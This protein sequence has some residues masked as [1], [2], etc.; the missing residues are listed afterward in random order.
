MPIAY[1]IIFAGILG[2]FF[3]EIPGVAN[4]GWSFLGS[5]WFNACILG[6][7]IFPLIIKKRIGE[8]S[9][10]GALLF[11]GVIVFNILLIVVKI[12]PSVET[13][14]QS[15]D[16]KRFY[17]F[18]FNIAFLSSLST[19]FVAYGFQSGFFPIYNALKKKSYRNGIKFATYSMG[20][21]FMIYVLIMFTGLYNFGT[22]IEGDV[23]INVSRLS[24]WE[25]YVIRTIFLLIMVTHTPFTFFL[26]KESVLCL[27]VLIYTATK[28]EE[29][30]EKYSK[31]LDEDQPEENQKGV[32]REINTS[33]SQIEALS[34]EGRSKSYAEEEIDE[35][36]LKGMTPEANMS[37]AIPFSRKSQKTAVGEHDLDFENAA[38]HE[39]LPDSIYYPT[40]ILL[41]M[42]VVGS[43]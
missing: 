10:A 8:L 3:N 24:A 19:A 43:A 26:G 21:S 17:R 33:N 13:D 25:S 42:V 35:K 16:Q 40:T 18:E 11:V 39:L 4:S 14:Y 37:L 1:F 34:N 27:A 5:Q 36:L 9:I 28:K 20:F 23:L 12:D 2:S 29:K 38:A 32:K 15:E 31:M 30:D 7:I 22:H 41:F 6:V